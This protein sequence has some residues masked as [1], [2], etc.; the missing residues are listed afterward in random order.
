M[1]ITTSTTIGIGLV[2]TLL[3]AAVSFGVMYDQ[4]QQTKETVAEI[5]TELKDLTLA[6]N[7]FKFQVVSKIAFITK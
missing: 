2:I 1:K 3:A 4:G 5:K 6:F 7:D